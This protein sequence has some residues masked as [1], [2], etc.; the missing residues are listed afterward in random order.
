MGAAL[1][2]SSALAQPVAAGAFKGSTHDTAARQLEARSA[3]DVYRFLQPLEQQYAGDVDY[4]YRL[5][6]AAVDSGRYSQAI[7]VLQRAVA[8]RPGFSGARM[9]LARAYYSQGD[10]EAARREFETLQ[11]QNPPPQ[12]AQAIAAYLDAIDRRAAAYQRQLS[13]YAELG[14]GFDSNAN[15]APDI[16][17]FIGIVLDSRNQA[18]SSPYYSLGAG[19]RVSHPFA[20]GWRLLGTGALGYRANPDASFVDSQVLRVAGGAEWRPGQVELSLQPNFATAKLDGEDNH[21]VAG[22]DFAGIWHLTRAQASLNVRS[23][24]TRYADGLEVL[25]VDTLVY[26]LAAQFTP[27]A[28]PRLQLLGSFTLGGDDAVEAL[29]PYGRDLSGARVGAMVGFGAS[30]SLL[31]SASTLM[32][33]YDGLFFGDRRDDEQLALALGYEWGGLRLRGWTLRAQL[34]YVD[35]TSSVALYDYD[36]LDAGVSLRREFR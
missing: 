7:F 12:A 3:D 11:D 28:L 5:G 31:V 9:E 23:S 19:G 29:S 32:A 27:L 24:R 26:G 14:S 30:H 33:D 6:T 1:L 10:N 18:A 15:G 4:D 36:R 2:S 13:G 8:T 16:Q 17:S 35:N 22:I 34:N 20:P 25:D 21:Q